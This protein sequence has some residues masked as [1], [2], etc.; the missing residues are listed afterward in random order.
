MRSQE[1][2]D[3]GLIVQHRPSMREVCGLGGL[4]MPEIE[5]SSMEDMLKYRVKIVC[6]LRGPWEPEAPANLSKK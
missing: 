1:I 4:W 5:R 2:P 6:I 3:S